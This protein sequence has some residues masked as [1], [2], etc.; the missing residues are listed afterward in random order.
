[1]QPTYLN[2]KLKALW[3]GGD[4]N[5]DQWPPEVWREDVRLMR[6]SGCQVA[7][8]GIFAWARM[9]P[10]EG[11]YDFGW[12]D[13]VIELL[14][15]GDRWFI[16]ATPSAAPP[17]WL[18]HKYPETLRTG[19]DRVRRLHGNRVNFNLSSPIYRE[20]TQEIARIL[21]ERY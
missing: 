3:H 20:K 14:E 1:M 15:S 12:L 19:A 13:E 16:L 17:A 21:A 10:E 11:R 5:P 2:P 8:I 4:Y 9:E 6:L 7:T 18:S